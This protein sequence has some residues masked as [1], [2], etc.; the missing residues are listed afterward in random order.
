MVLA[1]MYIVYYACAKLYEFSNGIL[2]I[3]KNVK[4][5]L[6]LIRKCFF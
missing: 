1:W 4:P 3:P 2:F 5:D 6:K